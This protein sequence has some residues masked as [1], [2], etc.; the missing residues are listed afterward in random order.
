MSYTLYTA[1][2][3]ITL[4]LQGH[5]SVPVSPVYSSRDTVRNEDQITSAYFFARLTIEAE[6]GRGKGIGARDTT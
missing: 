4:A 2:S 1:L 3:H 5:T 6:R